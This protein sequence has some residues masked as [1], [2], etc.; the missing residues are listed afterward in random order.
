MNP[1]DAKTVINFYRVRDPYGEFSNFY[2]RPITLD[3][4]VWPSSEHYYQAKKFLDEM[5]QEDIRLLPTPKEAAIKGRDES[6]PLRPDWELL[7]PPDHEFYGVAP[8]V[9][10]IKDASMW[11]GVIAK[12]TQH[13]D[14]RELLVKTDRA[15]LVEHTAN[16][17]YW[18]DGGDGTGAN[19]LGFMLMDVRRLIA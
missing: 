11:P 15:C 10:T 2:R 16:D 14:L 6:L 9:R 5:I 19:K 8:S 17:D 7:L 13:N 3:G 18:G 4:K 12:F 1:Y